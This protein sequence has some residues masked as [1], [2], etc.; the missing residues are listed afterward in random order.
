MSTLTKVLIVLLT[1]FS[2][3]LCGIVVTYVANADN[4]REEATKAKRDYTSARE[5]RRNAEDNLDKAKEAHQ[6]AKEAWETQKTELDN[7]VASLTSDLEAIRRE[8]RTLV[9][10]VANASKTV[11]LTTEIQDKQMAQAQTAQKEVTELRAEQTRLD[12]ELKETNQVLLEKMA[13]IAQFD[14]KN[15]QL[16]EANQELEKRINA[17]LR[18]Y[19][20]ITSEPAIVTPT[21]GIALPTET[22]AKDIDLNGQVTELDLKNGLAAISIGSAAGVDRKMQFHVT[23]GEEFV[24][25]IV[26]LDVEADKAVGD[27][28]RIQTQPQVGDRVTTNL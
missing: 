27:I 10:E 22:I 2:I 19:G 1:V 11:T 28:R 17:Y 26:I 20:K 9:Q 21:Q 3:F 15:K 24:C 13:I 16:M 23:R 12:K 8:N 5:M 6:A 4:Y 7:A 18:Q 14:E 25:D